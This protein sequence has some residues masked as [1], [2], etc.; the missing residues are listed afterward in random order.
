M[1][2]TFLD[3]IVHNDIDPCHARIFNAC[4]E[5]QESAIPRT[6]RQEK[7]QRLLQKYKNVRFLD[8]EDNQ[9]Y[10][11]APENFDIFSSQ[12]KRQTDNLGDQ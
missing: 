2:Y 6:E 9:T 8:D 12:C 11:I 4:I 5:Y 10:R 3:N 1:V 7:D